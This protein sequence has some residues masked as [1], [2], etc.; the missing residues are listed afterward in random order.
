MSVSS[1]DDKLLKALAAAIVDRPRA[2]LKELAEAAGISRAT[3]HRFCGTRDQ[4]VD[5]LENHG[6]AVLNEVI[7][8]AELQRSQP[9]EGLRRL[10]SE[11]LTHRELL[12]F[13]MFE[14]RPDSLDPGVGGGRWLSYIDSLDAFFLR[15]Q[16]IGTIRID[17]PAAVL[18]ELFISTIYGMVDA[19]RR[20]RAAS[21][22]SVTVLE[23]FFMNGAS[24]G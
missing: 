4:L 2:T 24:A 9:H 15:A 17:I 20:G 18:S 12:I 8:T 13:L 3:L 19:E 6:Q 22:S 5:M 23:E 21:S 7:E 10:I 1:N 14:Y 16:Q 11:H